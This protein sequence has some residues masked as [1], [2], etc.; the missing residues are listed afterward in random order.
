MNHHIEIPSNTCSIAA[1]W[2]ESNNFMETQSAP[3]ISQLQFAWV[4]LKHGL[5]GGVSEDVEAW[6]AS[7]PRATGECSS[8]MTIKSQ[9]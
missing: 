9:F 4:D 6:I 8:L 5:S 7:R 1:Y 3:V 2:V